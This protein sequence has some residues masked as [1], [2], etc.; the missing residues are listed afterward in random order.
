M[1]TPDTRV[2]TIEGLIEDAEK[3]A[4]AFVNELGMRSAEGHHAYWL[5]IR[6]NQAAQCALELGKAL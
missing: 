5:S 2:T 4:E 6:L 3:L 1:T